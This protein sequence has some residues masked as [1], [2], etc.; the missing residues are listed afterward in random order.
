VKASG[1]LQVSHNAE[2]NTAAKKFCTTGPRRVFSK[3]LTIYSGSF[4]CRP[5]R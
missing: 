1:S 5:M 3:L 4:L 2:L